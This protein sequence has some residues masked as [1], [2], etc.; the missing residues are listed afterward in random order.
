MFIK[1]DEKAIVCIEDI[2]AVERKNDVLYITLRNVANPIRIE[3]AITVKDS[4][5]KDY[6]DEIYSFI[7]GAIY[8]YRKT[9][10]D[11]MGDKTK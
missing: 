6:A 5:R 8:N 10:P 3:K 9:K 1:I 7:W 11:F 4:L 2:V